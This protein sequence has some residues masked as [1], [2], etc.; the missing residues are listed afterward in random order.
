MWDLHLEPEAIKLF[1]DDA[2]SIRAQQ[3]NYRHGSSL[4]QHRQDTD[5]PKAFVRF[6]GALR[7]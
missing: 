6:H 5:G 3:S 7:G 4:A 2:D 1:G